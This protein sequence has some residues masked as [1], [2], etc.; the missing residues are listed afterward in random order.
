MSDSRVIAYYEAKTA[1]ILAKYG[2]GPRVHF[3]SG[4]TDGAPPPGADP[5]ALGAALV[6]AQE[7]LVRDCAA[8]WCET[9]PLGGALLDVGCGLGGPALWFAMQHG[10]RVTALTD[11]AAHA[12]VVA[13]FATRAGVGDRVT[14]WVAD[15]H[16]LAGA[17]RFDAAL[18]IE[19]SCYLDRNAWFAAL[20]RVLRPGARVHVV[21]CFLGRPESS[22]LFDRYFLCRIGSLASYE[23]AAARAGFALEKSERLNGRAAGFWALSQAF[24]RAR[25]ASCTD[26]AEDARLRRSIAEHEGFRRAYADGTIDFLRVTFARAAAP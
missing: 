11:V 3:H 21:D 19:S 25:L 6:A 8:A 4:L 15:A 16:A 26:P 7:E 22:A 17:P 20:A 13:R 12:P 2:P 9:S 14:T 10:A 5:A 1:A 18:A 23:R 24:S